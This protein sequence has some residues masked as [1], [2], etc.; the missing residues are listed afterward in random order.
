MKLLTLGWVKIECLWWVNFQC[1]LTCKNSGI[2]NAQ[3]KKT[4][5]PEM[6]MTNSHAF[7]RGNLWFPIRPEIIFQKSSTNSHFTAKNP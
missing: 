2:T 1:L 7:G 3:V 4:V 5:L 6:K